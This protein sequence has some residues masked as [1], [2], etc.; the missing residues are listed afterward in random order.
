MK[1]RLDVALAALVTLCSAQSATA[2]QIEAR[3]TRLPT[4]GRSIAGTDDS[5]AL[6]QN[7]A[8]L[9][10]MPGAEFRWSSIYLDETNTVPW[11]GHALGLAFPIPILPIATGIRLDLV[12]PPAASAVN[13]FGPFNY[14]W[15]TWGL[16]A[17]SD[18]TAIG[19]SVQRSYSDAPFVDQLSSFS[20]GYSS[21]PLDVLGISL[22]AHDING[23][24]NGLF[25]LERSYDLAM[26]VR[27][28][29]T[30]A[31]EIG[32]EGKYVDR[33][34]DGFWVPRATLG[35]DIGPI[36]RLRGDFSVSRFEDDEKRA[37]IASAGLDLHFNGAAGS[38]SLG[39]G[40][41]T[42]NGLGQDDSFGVHMDI[43]PARGFREPTGPEVPRYALRIRVE[44]T[45]GARGQVAQLRRLWG[46]AEEP[47]ID[48]VVL[49]LRTSPARSLAHIQ[50]LRDAVHHLRKNGKRV[51]CHLED[52]GGAELYLCSAANK[53]LINPAGGL[54]FAGLKTQRMYFK[55]LL[56]KVGVKA[57]FV[58]IG[59]HK[60]APERLTRDGAS[61]TA[62]ADSI[63]LLQ[64]HERQF[65]EGVGTGRKIWVRGTSQANRQGAIHCKRSQDR[66]L[67]RRLR[68]R[69]R[70]GRSRQQAHRSRYDPDRRQ[71]CQPGARAVHP[72]QARRVG[73]RRRRHGGWP[74]PDHSALG[75]ETGGLLHHR[76]HLEAG[77]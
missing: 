23:P 51:L 70:A 66:G 42:G 16:A 36:G 32:L 46:I 4:L 49:E 6:V 61:E 39:G 19:V 34:R 8:N 56:D 65:V 27:P 5:T 30:R 26:A 77:A 75:N 11:Q 45:S 38:A 15:L 12:D 64:Q 67:G 63:D 52:A 74:K 25:A 13:G 50:E 35:I 9:V 55:S 57:D 69:R 3:P 31:L 1:R 44:D 43:A 2:Q 72:G 54:R 60:S 40:A 17:G 22:V 73:L 41:V 58:R 59:A 53:I 24:T 71:A 62:R 14:Q 48:A 7:P 37:W 29:G 10:F 76:G 20:V 68:L 21:R 18:T 28:L 47:S 33:P